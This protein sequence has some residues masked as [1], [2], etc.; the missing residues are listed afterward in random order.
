MEVYGFPFFFFPSSLVLFL[1][2]TRVTL[3]GRSHI[4]IHEPYYSEYGIAVGQI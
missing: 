1:K 3:T 2:E 4:G